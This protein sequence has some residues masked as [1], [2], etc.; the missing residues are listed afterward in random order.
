MPTSIYEP[1]ELETAMVHRIRAAVEEKIDRD[2]LDTGE[3]A[4]RLNLQPEGVEIL[5]AHSWSLQTAWRMAEAVGIRV[6]LAIRDGHEK[7]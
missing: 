5:R 4:R 2:N 1:T 6:D 7:N 3:L